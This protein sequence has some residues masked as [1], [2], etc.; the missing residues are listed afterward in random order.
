MT[1]L[2]TTFGLIMAIVG[3]MLFWNG[4]NQRFNL[5]RPNIKVQSDLNKTQDDTLNYSPIVPIL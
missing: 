4:I 2:W 3:L 1:R 5:T